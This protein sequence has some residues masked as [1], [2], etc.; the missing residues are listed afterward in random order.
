M[1]VQLTLYCCYSTMYVQQYLMSRLQFFEAFV[2]TALQFYIYT[3]DNRYVRSGLLPLCPCKTTPWL[4]CC[5]K[6]ESL[7]FGPLVIAIN[8][9][10]PNAL[11]LQKLN[12]LSFLWKL[13]VTLQ[14]QSYKFN[15]FFHHIG[16][17]LVKVT[18]LKKVVIK[19]IVKS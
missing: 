17:W 12:I 8:S 9:I 16:V 15:T 18:F 10:R 7:A 5:F 14:C 6:E 11:H 19:M 4:I 3:K 13:I 2:K 1:S